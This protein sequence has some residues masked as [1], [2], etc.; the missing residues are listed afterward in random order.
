MSNFYKLTK[1]IRIRIPHISSIEV[2][3]HSEGIRLLLIKM[4][5]GCQLN[6]GVGVGEDLDMEDY[7][8][9]DFLDE[10]DNGAE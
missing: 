3:P 7:Q 6:L 10:V 8:L 1:N 9:N 4:M 2:K 5:N